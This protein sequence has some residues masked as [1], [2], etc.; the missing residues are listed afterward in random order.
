M[1]AITT[2]RMPRFALAT[3]LLMALLVVFFATPEGRSLAMRVLEL[4]TRVEGTT[5]PMEDDQPVPFEPD[6]N[7]PTAL[8]PAPLISVAEAE[9][10]VGFNVATIPNVPEGFIYLGAR[11]YGKNVSIEYQAQGGGGHLILMQSKDGFYQSD[12][13]RVPAE[14]VV[15]VKIRELDGEF[16]QG[17]FVIFPGETNATWHRDASIMRLRWV[18]NG[19]WFEMTKHGNAQPI[20][21]LDQ[22]EMILLAESLTYY[23]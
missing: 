19:V 15:P 9:A 3:L 14:A 20:E 1:N 21:Y 5:F 18:N 16:A 10:Q 4:F 11:L 8:P 6:Q 13:D 2:H 17:T 23:P 12:W 7:P 22:A